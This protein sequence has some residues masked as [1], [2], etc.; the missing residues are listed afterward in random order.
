MDLNK[1]IEVIKS[2]MTPSSDE[3]FRQSVSRS[4][5]RTLDVLGQTAGGLNDVVDSLIGAV[6]PDK[7]K[8]WGKEAA[9]SVLNTDLGRKGLE[10]MKTGFDS[11]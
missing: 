2:I 8:Q 4:P 10:A 1:R 9:V 6:I 5:G 7:V 11:A 3:S